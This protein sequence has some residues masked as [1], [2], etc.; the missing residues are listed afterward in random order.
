MK[1][2][3]AIIKYKRCVA[4]NFFI[5]SLYIT[6]V[7]AT[8]RNRGPLSS[9]IASE[10]DVERIVSLPIHAIFGRLLLL[11]REIGVFKRWM[12]VVMYSEIMNE[13]GSYAALHT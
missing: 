10:E 6:H 1:S 9:D 3:D 13:I 2:D 7:F 5:I 11:I 12:I 4:E 8:A